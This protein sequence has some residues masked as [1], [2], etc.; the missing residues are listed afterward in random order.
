MVSSDL[1]LRH[2]IKIKRQGVAQDITVSA[3]LK[4]AEEPNKH[5]L[6]S[7]VPR[8][9]SPSCTAKEKLY[10]LGFEDITATKPQTLTSTIFSKGGQKYFF[11]VTDEETEAQRQ[12]CD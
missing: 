9:G 11:R 10:L 4:L 6:A 7:D 12:T 1:K 3:P 8:V 5:H 2:Y